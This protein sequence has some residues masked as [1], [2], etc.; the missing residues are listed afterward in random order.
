MAEIY[1][2]Y[3]YAAW[4]DSSNFMASSDN[5]LLKVNRKKTQ[6]AL[7]MDVG[8]IYRIASTIGV[9][10]E[11]SIAAVAI[12]RAWCHSLPSVWTNLGAFSYSTTPAMFSIGFG[13]LL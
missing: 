3:R 11:L 12:L 5:R 4:I 1:Y 13:T 2:T 10:A 6:A 7:V 8:H 9:I